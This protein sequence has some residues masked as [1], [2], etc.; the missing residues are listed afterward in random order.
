MGLAVWWRIQ[1]PGHLSLIE[2]SELAEVAHGDQR[3]GRLASGLAGAADQ[4]LGSVVAA[5]GELG[6]VFRIDADTRHGVSGSKPG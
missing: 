4:A 5:A 1:C 6:Y 2:A 3:P